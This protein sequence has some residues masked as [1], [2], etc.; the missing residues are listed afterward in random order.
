MTLKK[1]ARE[2]CVQR[3]LD[4]SEIAKEVMVSFRTCFYKIIFKIKNK[5]DIFKDVLKYMTHGNQINQNPYFDCFEIL[6]LFFWD[7]MFIFHYH[8]G[9]IN[10]F[11]IN[12]LEHY[13]ISCYAY[14]I[15]RLFRVSFRDF[16][17][18]YEF[19]KKNQ[20][21]CFALFF[22]L[23]HVI[24]VDQSCV[25]QSC[26]TLHQVVL[27]RVS[28]NQWLIPVLLMTVNV[29]PQKYPRIFIIKFIIYSEYRLNQLGYFLGIFK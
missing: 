28:L 21:F 6:S 27:E 13:F 24:S 9:R 4:K 7:I 17:H 12:V 22:E 18:F 23:R 16:Y 2:I 19:I 5:K 10:L 8:F 26:Y 25:D 3:N 14:G 20:R 29:T 11:L 1:N 15:N